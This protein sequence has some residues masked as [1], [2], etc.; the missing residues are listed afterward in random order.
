LEL[1]DFFIV[2][3][4]IL[5]ISLSFIDIKH[6]AVPDYLL[7]FLVIVGFLTP[8]FSI[9]TA[10]IFAGAFSLL[11]LFVTTYIHNIKA[12]FVDI[13][14]DQKSLGEGDIPVIAVIGGILGIKLGV[15]AIFL[16]AIVAIF[17]AL[18]S[19]FAKQEIETPFIPYLT[20]GFTLAYFFESYIVRIIP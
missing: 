1:S 7:V 14:S 3:I 8:S 17:P 4:F 20:I 6:K 18:Y 10:L 13:P 9:Q 16:S 5:L 11:E 2:L 15:V 19:Q 12:K